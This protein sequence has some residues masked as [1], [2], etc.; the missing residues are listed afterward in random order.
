MKAK[1]LFLL[2]LFVTGVVAG[3]VS[4]FEP[5]EHPIEHPIEH[6]VEHPVDEEHPENEHVSVNEERV[7]EEER[8]VG[9]T[10]GIEDLKYTEIDDWPF[11][12]KSGEH[13]VHYYFPVWL[14]IANNNEMMKTN[15]TRSNRTIQKL[16][17]SKDAIVISNN[18]KPFISSNV[19]LVIITNKT[20]DSIIRILNTTNGNITNYSN[21]TSLKNLFK[22]NLV[23]ISTSSGLRVIGINGTKIGIFSWN[24]YEGKIGTP[25]S[26]K[27]SITSNGTNI[28][29]FTFT[30]TRESTSRSISP[31]TIFWS[32]ILFLT[33]ALFIVALLTF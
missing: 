5:V 23:I 28:I 6:P 8:I 27:V 3:L 29:M 19:S 11:F 32:F 2:V 21:L 33:I 24:K 25:S 16:I 22:N 15:G 4:A 1:Y 20:Y 26:V 9:R 18:I 31:D 13:Y 7:S 10:F 30:K 17:F 12:Y 14:F